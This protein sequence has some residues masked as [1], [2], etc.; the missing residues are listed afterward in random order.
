MVS[1]VALMVNDAVGSVVVLGI[2][3]VMVVCLVTVTVESLEIVVVTPESDILEGLLE[4]GGVDDEDGG[5]GLEVGLG[6]DDGDA[7]LMKSSL[8]VVADAGD[9]VESSDDMTDD[10][11]V[12]KVDVVLEL[13]CL[14]EDDFAAEDELEES[15][16]SCGLSG[17]LPLVQTST[18][19][20]P[21]KPLEQR[22]HCVFFG[23]AVGSSCAAVA[24]VMIT[25]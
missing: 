6:V 8:V 2:S 22:Y 4:V 7:L 9:D 10:V 5:D 17:Q 11:E 20:H 19:Q 15:S 25:I 3:W 16:G 12:A 18:E 13:D 21:A 1:W 14:V 23:Q 24:S